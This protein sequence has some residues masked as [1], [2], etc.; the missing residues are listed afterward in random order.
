[1]IASTEHASLCQGRC[2]PYHVGGAFLGLSIDNNSVVVPLVFLLD[3]FLSRSAFA[4]V[5]YMTIAVPAILNV[6]PFRMP[7][8]GGRW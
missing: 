6:T 1:M 4:A 7:K 2:Q 8:P 3:G 5:L